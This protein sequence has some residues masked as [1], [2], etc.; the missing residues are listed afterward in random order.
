MQTGLKN[1]EN[2]K[3]TVYCIEYNSLYFSNL[4]IWNPKLRI[5]LVFSSLFFSGFLMKE[6][7]LIYLLAIFCW[8]NSVHERISWWDYVSHLLIS[9]DCHHHQAFSSFRSHMLHVSE[10]APIKAFCG[11]SFYHVQG[12]IRAQFDPWRLHRFSFA[13]VCMLSKKSCLQKRTA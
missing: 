2:S 1:V 12:W 10:P 13:S 4:E 3:K 9:R 5:I 8:R 11:N 6:N 7:M